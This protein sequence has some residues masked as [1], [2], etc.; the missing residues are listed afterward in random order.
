MAKKRMQLNTKMILA[1]LATAVISII[2]GIIGTTSNHKLTDNIKYFG[3]QTL[4]EVKHITIIQDEIDRIIG[5]MDKL[6]NPELTLTQRAQV[7]KDIADARNI[8]RNSFNVFKNLNETEEEK[9]HLNEFINAVTAWANANDKSFQIGQ[10]IEESGILNPA[11]FKTLI[12]I[13]IKD[14]HKTTNALSHYIMTGKSFKGGTDHT[15]C[16]FGKYLDT[17]NSTNPNITMLMNSITEPHKKWHKHIKEIKNLL[18]K[19]QKTKAQKLYLE[20]FYPLAEN[21]LFP[22]FNNLIDKSEIIQDKYK[23]LNDHTF[24]YSNKQ[25][26]KTTAMLKKI[27][28]LVYEKAE[29]R[30]HTAFVA[31]KTSLWIQI[32]VVILGTI[33][34]VILGI[35]ISFSISN[36]LRKIIERLNQGSLQVAEASGQV[37]NASQ[38]MASGASQQA[39]S[40]EESSSSLEEMSSMTKQ[41][42]ENA[43]QANQLAD[44]A[45]HATTEGKASMEK[46]ITAINKIKSSSDETANIIK[47]IDDIAFQT[48]LLALNAAVEAARAGEAGKGF[49]VVAEEVRNLAQRSAEAA[50]N[51]SALIE[52]S[53]ENSQNGVAVSQE[54]SESLNNISGSITKVSS[55]VA[56]VSAASEE[57]SKGIEQI[58]M[59]VAE[60]NSVTQSNAANSEESAAASEEL[61]AQAKELGTMVDELVMLVNGQ[62]EKR[63]ED[64]F[65]HHAIQPTKNIHKQKT[66]TIVAKP[67]TKNYKTS[68]TPSDIIPLDDN[69]FDDF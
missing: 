10:E 12:E 7:K 37:S 65:S 62:V 16:N 57:Q 24:N 40:L 15:A 17:F 28:E 67:S 25:K 58:N 60:M 6:L 30:K 8:Y 23:Q 69:D 13:F 2:I 21:E 59:A 56:E 46:M 48:N 44:Q 18:S 3:N 54:V 45:N 39:S 38:H 61:S 51:T 31:S 68:S 11:K 1:F 26:I 9:E 29:K 52:E 50:K 55:L 35:V 4:P 14:H 34:A 49:A 63:E 33:F 5:N 47:T 36:P 19:G 27:S 66:T 41:N 53:R 43:R 32:V 64:S 22:V 42:A 20:I